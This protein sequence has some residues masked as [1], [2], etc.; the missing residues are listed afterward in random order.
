MSS[1]AS[2]IYAAQVASSCCSRCAASHRN[3][4]CHADTQLHRSGP[5][6][7]DRPLA[8]DLVCCACSRQS[9]GKELQLE[10]KVYMF[11]PGQNSKGSF[12]RVT[13]SGLG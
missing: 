4:G 6:H 13:E 11:S 1:A 5:L 7:D 2:A 12:L 10:N 9:I 3:H 8:H